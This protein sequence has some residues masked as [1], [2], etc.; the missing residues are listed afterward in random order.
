MVGL[1]SLPRGDPTAP[2]LAAGVSGVQD[3]SVFRDERTLTAALDRPLRL[4]IEPW[5]DERTIP[6]RTVVPL[7]AEGPQERRIEV[8]EAADTTWVAAAISRRT[9]GVPR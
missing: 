4:W 1:G 8:V 2:R 9:R 6:P 3:A 7:R 5:A